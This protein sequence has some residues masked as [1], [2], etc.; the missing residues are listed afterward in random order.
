MIVEEN[1]NFLLKNISNHDWGKNRGR[2]DS[3]E[4]EVMENRYIQS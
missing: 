2:T 1:S 4:T 3:S